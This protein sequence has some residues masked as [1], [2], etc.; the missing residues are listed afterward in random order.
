[1][2]ERF[3]TITGEIDSFCQNIVPG[4]RAK[5]EALQETRRLLAECG[6]E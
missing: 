5:E 2:L 3:E 4:I 6:V 1:M